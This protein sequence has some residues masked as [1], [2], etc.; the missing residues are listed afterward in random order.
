MAEAL[1]EP[2]IGALVEALLHKVAQEANVVIS[3]KNDFQ[4]LSNKLKYL[5]GLLRDASRKSRHNNSINA[6]LHEIEDVA[7]DAEDICEECLLAESDAEIS[8]CTNF[9]SYTQFFFRYRMG[10]RIKDVKDRIQSILGNATELNLIHNL[11]DDHTRLPAEAYRK[12]SSLLSNET[13]TVGMEEKI[14]MIMNWLN[15]PETRVIAVVGMGG[16]GKT[17]LL[18][19][20]FKRA[21]KSFSSSIWLSISQD[22][23]VKELQ[24]DIGEKIGLPNLKDVSLEAAGESIHERLQG[25][26]SLIVLDDVWEEEDRLVERIG[27]PIESTCKIVITSRMKAVCTK[28]GADRVYDMELLSEDDSWKLFCFHAFSDCGQTPPQEIEEVARD[29]EKM[30]GRLPLAVKTVAA[31]MSSIKRLPNEWK[32]RL[33]RLNEEVIPNNIMPILRLSYDALPAYL[34]QCFLYCSAFPED[35]EIDVEYLINLWIAEGFIH[36]ENKEDLMDVALSYVNELTDRC[37]IEVS[38]SFILDPE[39]PPLP[40]VNKVKIGEY[41][42][43][44]DLLRDLS[45]SL[46]KEN[47]CVFDAGKGSPKFLHSQETRGLRRISLR[48]REKR[49]IPLTNKFPGLRTILLTDNT[50]IER[51]IPDGFIS[52][53]KSLRVLDLSWTGICSLP[54]SIEKLK[55]LRFLNLSWTHIRELPHSVRGLKSLQYLDVSWCLE[56]ERLPKEI[57]ELHC[58]KHL[59]AS[60]CC[61]LKF[62]PTWISKLTSLETLRGFIFMEGQSGLRIEDLKGLIQLRELQLTIVNEL[63]VGSMIEGLVKMRTLY[64]NNCGDNI[65]LP[66]SE[67]IASLK[68]LEHLKLFGF[69]VVPDCVSS[70]QNLLVLTLESCFCTDYPALEIMPNLRLLSLSQNTCCLKLRKEFGKSGGFPKLE[71]LDVISF[72]SLEEFPEL[73]DGAMP[74][75]KSLRVLFCERV[76]KRPDEIERL[77]NLEQ[78]YVSN[79]GGWETMKTGGEDWKKL[80]DRL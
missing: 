60:N 24:A 54:K 71:R 35:E 8:H 59:D 66:F 42:R 49:S 51:L 64:L 53:L 61:L 13:Q 38:E 26:R 23:S 5:K 19:N 72:D 47:K 63:G 43:M 50:I 2:V 12:K 32:F 33:R 18:Q 57:G 76:K 17:F 27:L 10:R 15:D 6:W 55:L 56:L 30:C 74:R 75:L 65:S 29:I 39:E 62:M 69:S 40:F 80:T 3:F 45:L 7:Y 28:M 68:E 73:E 1:V 46:V 77:I 31:A 70:F 22:Y 11:T 14:E 37:L 44:H 34:K 52:N 67:K 20:V 4:W 25:Q 58:L 16:L 36:T 78:I 21:K 41:L 9:C 79:C 48:R